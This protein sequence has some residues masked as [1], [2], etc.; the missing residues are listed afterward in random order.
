MPAKAI[1][2]HPPYFFQNDIYG[3]D[4]VL[5]LI[6]AESKHFRQVKYTLE[7]H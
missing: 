6:P 1:A 5:C 4:A 3:N 7:C 2:M